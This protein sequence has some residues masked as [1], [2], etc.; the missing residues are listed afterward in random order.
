MIKAVIFDMY[1]TLITHYQSTLYFGRQIAADAGIPEDRFCKLWDATEQDRT[2]G[3]LTF[4]EVI[5]T[6]LRENQCYSDTLFHAIVQKRMQVKEECFAHIHK[7][8]VP[9]LSGL[10]EKGLKVGL[11]SNCFSEETAA[12]R[13]SVLFSYFDVACLS[14]EQGIQKPDAEIFRRCIA[15]L[16]V[17]AD[18]CLYVGDGGSHE[19]EAAQA[20]GMKAV[21][22]VWYLREG[23]NQP[24]GR[25][26]GFLQVEQPL[27]LISLHRNMTVNGNN[28]FPALMTIT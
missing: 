23:T 14:Y 24:C 8:I 20:V 17:E 7:D 15:K 9:L 2:I 25:K 26:E 19:L 4:E 5:E 22:A 28:L 12:I 3:K 27:D 6:I 18:E 21:Q 16:K 1:E 13:K 11:I 10:R